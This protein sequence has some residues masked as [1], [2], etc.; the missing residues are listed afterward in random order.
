MPDARAARSASRSTSRPS[1]DCTTLTAT[2]SNSGARSPTAAS[3][4]S[5]TETPRSPCT[6]NG[7]LTL[8]NSPAATS[9]RVPS[10]TAAATS[11]RSEDTDAP[12]ATR[13]TGTPAKA[14]NPAR[15]ASTAGSWSAGWAAPVRH[16]VTAFSTAAAT[17]REGIPMLAVFR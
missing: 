13:S 15:P 2:T 9:T 11:P 7:Q 16:A 8:V 17:V 14:A 3:S 5:V 12:M 6:A 1:A 10:G 4:H